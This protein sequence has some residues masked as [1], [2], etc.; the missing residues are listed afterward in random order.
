M[1]C[2]RCGHDRPNRGCYVCGETQPE[3]DHDFDPIESEN[4]PTEETE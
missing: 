1:T 2:S 3:P 4:E